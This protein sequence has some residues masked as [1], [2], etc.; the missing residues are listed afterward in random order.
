MHPLCEEKDTLRSRYRSRMSSLPGL[1]D[2]LFDET[3]R[4]RSGPVSHRPRLEIEIES[5]F[6]SAANANIDVLIMIG[7]G[8]GHHRATNRPD[9]LGGRRPHVWTRSRSGSIDWIDS[10]RAVH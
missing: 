6:L 9:G 3:G 4:S 8:R 1:T 10:S 7:C 2:R 5:N